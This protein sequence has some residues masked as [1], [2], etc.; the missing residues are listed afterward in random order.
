MLPDKRAE[1]MASCR[2]CLGPQPPWL[3]VREERR[4]LM[5]DHVAARPRRNHDRFVSGFERRDGVPCGGLGVVVKAGVISG[6]A[7]ARLVER[8]VDLV[9]KVL[10]YAHDGKA[11]VGSELVDE[12]GMKELN[13][14]HPVNNTMRGPEDI[15]R[16][17]RAVCASTSTQS[18][19]AGP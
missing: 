8:H 18:P 13:A 5:D 15:G 16:G 19:R 11:G 14:R 2:E 17:Q 4:V 7:A 9:A 3:V 6:L 12:T 10:E 1:L